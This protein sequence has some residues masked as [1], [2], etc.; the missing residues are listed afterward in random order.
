[1]LPASTSFQ[2]RAHDLDDIVGGLF[3]RFGIARHVVSNVIFHQLG[4]EAVDGAARG[5]QAL[6]GIS[7][8]LILVECA[9]NA[10]E[11][12]DDFLGAIDELEFFF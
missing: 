4:H 10:F 9:K 7:A 1:L 2:V 12:A 6:E 3:R 8:G 5:G 11:L